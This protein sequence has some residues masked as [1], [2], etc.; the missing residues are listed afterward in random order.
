LFAEDAFESF[1][2]NWRSP[3]HKPTLWNRVVRWRAGNP[4]IAA[5]LMVVSGSIVIAIFPW[6]LMPV[7]PSA[8]R[9]TLPL[10]NYAAVTLLV[11]SISIA[12]AWRKRLTCLDVE[13]LRPMRRTTL[14]CEWAASLASDL[15]P[16]ALTAGAIATLSFEL[17]DGWFS[18]IAWQALIAG[19]GEALAMLVLLSGAL[20]LASLAFASIIVVIER[21]WLGLALAFGTFLLGGIPFGA[22]L[23]RLT[24]QM[25]F[26]P[27]PSA[28]IPLL[29]IP[30]TVSAVALI[31]MWRLW[32]RIDF[33]RRA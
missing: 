15:L 31:C 17:R 9:L 6:I 33:D 8:G 26:A 29:L 28:A 7:T 25:R 1:V 24:R 2:E 10:G 22:M 12:Y 30:V 14:Q 19:W 5:V 18:A 32:T 4:R 13:S 16:P 3:A 21:H 23:G 20:W 27:D 11:T